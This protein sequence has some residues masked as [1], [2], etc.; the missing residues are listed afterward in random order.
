[1][2]QFGEFSLS[3]QYRRPAQVRKGALL[4]VETLNPA[5]VWTAHWG[6]C[7][8][9][10]RRENRKPHSFPAKAWCSSDFFNASSAARFRS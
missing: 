4:V 9:D 2:L 5:D 1:L 6:K 10:W 3:R 8:A 7:S